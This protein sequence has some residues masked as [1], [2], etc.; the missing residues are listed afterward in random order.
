MKNNQTNL[1]ELLQHQQ[2]NQFINVLN[3]L[4]VYNKDICENVQ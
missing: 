3:K 2:S 4:K 1:I